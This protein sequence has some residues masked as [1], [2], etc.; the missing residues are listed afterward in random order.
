MS[1]PEGLALAGGDTT[2]PDDRRSAKSGSHF[3]SASRDR[4]PPRHSHRQVQ[5]LHILQGWVARKQ[6]HGVGPPSFQ[7]RIGS[8]RIGCARMEAPQFGPQGQ[9]FGAWPVSI[10]V[11]PHAVEW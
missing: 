3:S 11:P 6:R 9:C 1:D 10:P 8:D 7:P 2:V 5:D 4:C